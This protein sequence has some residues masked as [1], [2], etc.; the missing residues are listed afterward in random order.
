MKLMHEQMLEFV[1]LYSKQWITEHVATFEYFMP[2][3][4]NEAPLVYA[5]LIRYDKIL[6]IMVTPAIHTRSLSVVVCC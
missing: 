5:F 1:R 3:L 4:E 2:H 6:E